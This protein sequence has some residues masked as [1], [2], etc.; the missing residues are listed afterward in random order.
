MAVILAENG[1]TFLL[2]A[3]EAKRRWVNVVS[4]S[5]D[6]ELEEQVGILGRMGCWEIEENS[7][8]PFLC[9]IVIHPAIDGCI[10]LH[11][12]VRDRGGDGGGGIQDIE[13][14]QITP[15]TRP[16]TN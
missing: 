1:Y 4:D 9:G 2:K 6:N 12:R 8:K 10:R 15:P 5:N 11:G 7:F 13:D 16:R 3:V 14:I